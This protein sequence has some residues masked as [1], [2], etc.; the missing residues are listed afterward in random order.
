MIILLLPLLALVEKAVQ[1]QVCSTSML[2][3]SS[4]CGNISITNKMYPLGPRLI[5][6]LV[7]E[8]V[9]VGSCG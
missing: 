8:D 3:F 6:W 7:H 1:G 4:C 5:T 9:S 2:E